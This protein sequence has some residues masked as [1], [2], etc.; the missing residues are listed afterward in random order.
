MVNYMVNYVVK[1]YMVKLYD[2]SVNSLLM[3]QDNSNR[4]RQS[5]IHQTN[6]KI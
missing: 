4:L 2:N 6:F 5:I 1:N 3:I